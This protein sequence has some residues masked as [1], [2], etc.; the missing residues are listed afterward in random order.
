MTPKQEQQLRDLTQSVARASHNLIFAI[1]IQDWAEAHRMLSGSPRR[2]GNDI[3]LLGGLVE[4][5][6]QEDAA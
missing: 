6:L 5:K 2:I 4:I 3:A 1:Q